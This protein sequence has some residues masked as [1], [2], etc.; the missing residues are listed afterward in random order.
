[1]N[2]MT[3][4]PANLTAGGRYL[5][6]A[7]AFLGWLFAGVQMA[8]TPLVSRS[9]T[10]ELLWPDQVTQS[11]EKGQ[12]ELVGRWFAWHNAS[13][14]LGAAVG[15]LLFGWLG[16]HVGR[17]RAMALSI[18]CY[19]VLTGACYF[20]QSAEHL[21][22]LRFLACLGV[23]GMWPNGVA[24]VSEAWPDVSRPTLAGIIG[25]SANVGIV[26]LSLLTIYV[27]VTPASW[28]WVLLVGA[29]PAVLGLFVSR[30]L[31]ESPRWLA[32][33]QQRRD[34]AAIP[35]IE[36][37]RPPLLA[38]TLIGICLGTIPLLGGWGSG[39]WLTPWADE[40][41]GVQD[42]SLKGWTHV[43]RGFGG[44]LGSLAGGWLAGVMG[45]RPAYFCISVGSLAISQHIF[46]DLTPLH[47]QFGLW[48][49]LL[50][51]VSGLYF[52]WL[53]LC[54]PE[55]FP[56]RVRSTG[57]GVAFNFG[58]VAAAAGVLG[59]GELIKS[60]YGGDYGK[61][62]AL[63]SLIYV[64]GVI[65]IWIAPDTSRRSMADGE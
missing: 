17:T 15:G 58:R 5:I 18:L 37:F 2:T 14:L 45:R 64:V 41:G 20:V 31:P 53:P 16:D 12:R 28:R 30:V 10:V 65:V 49:F 27:R 33:R 29:A 40:V 60:Q 36:V 57:A 43:T 63:T 6:L 32:A 55:L 22:V 25:T 54:L 48:A 7:A 35:A 8:I 26:L 52:G 61:V 44:T 51:L 34:G 4:T 39:N 3:Q 9:A 23:G 38:L 50:G 19:S 59:A 13:F 42:P 1:M 21:L 56:T 62:G 47:S 11:L 46:R 24:L